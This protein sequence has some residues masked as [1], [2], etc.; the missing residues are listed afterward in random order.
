MLYFDVGHGGTDSGC[1]FADGTFEKDY[2]LKMGLYV[3][4][5]VKKYMDVKINRTTDISLSLQ[6]RVA[7]M[8]KYNPCDVFSFHCNANDKNTRGIEI[9]LSQYN[10]SEKEF[11]NY[12]LKE[13]CKVFNMEN[14]GILIR[15]LNNGQDYY[16]LHR[17][18]GSNSKVKILELG[19]GDNTKDLLILKNKFNQIGDFIAQN[20]LLKYNIS[21]DKDIKSTYKSTID[22]LKECTD[23]PDVWFNKL[24]NIPNSEGLIKQV[25]YRNKNI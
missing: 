25:Y 16:Y 17:A 19:F 23:Y 11:C 1:I 4:N 10:Q 5:V 14:R 2:N 21:M 9:L 22:I 12:F 3:Y 15:K 7:D 20:M 13:Y 24:K 6:D 8:K 18:S